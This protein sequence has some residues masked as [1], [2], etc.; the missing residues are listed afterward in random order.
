MFRASLRPSSGDQGR[1][2][3]DMG[4]CTGCAGCGCVV[5][6]R[7]CCALCEVRTVTFTQYTQHLR[8]SST[9]PRPAQTVQNT[10][11]AKTR[12]CSPDDGHNDA[13]NMLR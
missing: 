4:F 9:Q 10:I 12:T 11:C 8:H 3:A 13:R 5:L 7:K 6:G 1:V 2:L